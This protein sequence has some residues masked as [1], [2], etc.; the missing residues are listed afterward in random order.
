M[1]GSR[2]DL[3]DGRVEYV[4][5]GRV[6]GLLY[7]L[8]RYPGAI[9]DAS[10]PRWIVGDVV[11]LVTP[12]ATLDLLD[13]YEGCGV[14]DPRPHA[15]ERVPVRVSLDDGTGVDAWAYPYRGSLESARHVLSGDYGDV[16]R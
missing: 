7:D 9:V 1:R 11:R 13:A 10:S 16:T 2:F 4:G 3:L 8:G 12:S 6:P 5:R 15:F 14:H